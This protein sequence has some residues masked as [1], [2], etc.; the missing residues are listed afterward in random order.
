MA[1]VYGTNNADTMTP[2]YSSPGVIGRP[3]DQTDWIFA[4]GGNDYIYAAGGRDFIYAGSGND[5]IYGG[6]G[7]DFIDGQK[8][9][10]SMIGGAGNDTYIVDDSGDI[11]YEYA[12]GGIDTVETVG[13]Y[14]LQ[15][16][17]HLENLTLLGGVSFGYGNNANNVIDARNARRLSNGQAVKLRGEGG[18]DMIRGVDSFGTTD[19]IR[20]G[21]QS[22]TLYGNAG[23]DRLYGDNDMDFL[24]G[25]RDNDT[26]IGGGYTDSLRGDG[27]DDLLIGNS[28]KAVSDQG[29][30]YDA[31]WGGFGRDTFVLGNFFGVFYRDAGYATLKDFVPFIDKIRVAGSKSDY[32][33]REGNFIGGGN[34]DTE[35]LHRGNRIALVDGQT[36]LDL[37]ASYF[38]WV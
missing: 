15:S 27:G 38:E 21:S 35:I 16:R 17:P 3:T 25:G 11:I 24:Y 19:E 4:Y 10:D 31:L 12:G 6:D 32:R 2:W 13:S 8:G 37:N 1:N 28:N 18:N 23:H 7:D 36:G 26:L 33:L 5:T 30:E 29:P 9:A 20:G 14:S 34:L 22:D